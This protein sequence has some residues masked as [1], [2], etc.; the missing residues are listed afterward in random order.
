MGTQIGIAGVMLGGVLVCAHAQWLNYPMPGTPRTRDGHPNLSAKAPRASNGRPD[1]SG[2]W[3]TEFAP[4]GENERLFGDP[5]RY[6]AVPG[7]DPGTFSKYALN[8]LADFKTEESP[9]RPEAAELFRRNTEA[10][11]TVR[12]YSP[13]A[14]CLP[15]GLPRADLFN[16]APFKI[17]QT[18]AVIAV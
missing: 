1:L 6:A 13:T 14:L 7:D 15:Q 16:Y 4:S 3:R 5:V 10:R 12:E 11:G 8:I 18:P 17:I 9:M 2:V